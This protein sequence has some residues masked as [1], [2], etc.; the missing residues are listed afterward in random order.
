MGH[1]YSPDELV[2]GI[3]PSASDYDAAKRN[4]MDG[5]RYLVDQKVL[6]GAALLGSITYSDF[7][8]GSDIDLFAV[9]ESHS[10]EEVLR[11][12]SFQIT[13]ATHVH[14]DI[15]TVTR[16]AAQS[17]RHRLLYY[18]V[19]TIREFCSKWAIGA[20]PV[21]II[22]DRDKWCDIQNE[23]AEDLAAR[24]D[25][26]VKARLHTRPDL[27]SSH[28]SLLDRIVTLPV[29]AAIGIV[30]LK[31]GGQPSTNGRR[32][33]K[34]ETCRLYERIIPGETAAMLFEILRR[35]QQYRQ[36]LKTPN[37]EIDAYCAMLFDIDMAYPLACAVIENST[38]YLHSHRLVFHTKT[39]HP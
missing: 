19:H 18:Y 28:C 14:F 11:D 26:L 24:V 1:I 6:Y 35:K 34:V 25:A 31:Y 38:A 22:A 2:R 4:M 20:N 33:S 39:P 16:Q 15:K 32:L 29:Y 27:G 8:L 23:L 37:I 9:I 30:R 10:G 3:I 17:G 21:A 36:A 13:D 12:L 5:L 7:E